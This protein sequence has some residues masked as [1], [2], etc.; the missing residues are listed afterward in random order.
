MLENRSEVTAEWAAETPVPALVLRRPGGRR[1][2]EGPL[3][4]GGRPGRGIPRADAHSPRAALAEGPKGAPVED[5]VGAGSCSSCCRR[6][7]PGL[8]ERSCLAQSS[9]EDPAGCPT[10]AVA[11]P[12]QGQLVNA[13]E[14]L[15]RALP[16]LCAPGGAVRSPL[17]GRGF[18]PH[19]CPRDPGSCAGNVDVSHEPAERAR[20]LSRNRRRVRTGRRGLWPAGEGA[21][22]RPA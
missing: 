4:G 21:Q 8:R 11:D 14:G 12:A 17:A 13:F 22:A 7:C 16:L 9:A 3:R 1:R 19:G 10:A 18:G 2:G 15:S 6:P 20:A 5:A